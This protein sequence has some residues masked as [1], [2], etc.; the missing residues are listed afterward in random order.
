MATPAKQNHW[1]KNY[2][3]FMTP[4]KAHMASIEFVGPNAG[5]LDHPKDLIRRFD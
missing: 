1:L 2:F 4:T 5:N 3:K